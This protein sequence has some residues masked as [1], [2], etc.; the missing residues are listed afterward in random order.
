MLVGR[1]NG[2]TTLENTVV[3]SYKVKPKYDPVAI[4]LSIYSREIN[5]YSLEGLMLKLELQYFGHLI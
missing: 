4:F 1:Q 5:K 3:L 2:V